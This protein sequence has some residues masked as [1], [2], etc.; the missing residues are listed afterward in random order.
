LFEFRKLASNYSALLHNDFQKAKLRDPGLCLAE[1]KSDK[2]QGTVS[3]SE[4]R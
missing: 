2:K 3:A 4:K 1:R